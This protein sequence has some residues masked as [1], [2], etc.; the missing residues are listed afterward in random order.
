MDLGPSFQWN[1]ELL[2][3]LGARQM[4]GAKYSACLLACRNC[5][6]IATTDSPSR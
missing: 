4:V 3:S 6:I 5:P 2:S 1:I